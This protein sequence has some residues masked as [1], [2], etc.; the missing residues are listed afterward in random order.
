MK[1]VFTPRRFLQLLSN[2]D[3]FAWSAAPH[4]NAGLGESYSCK[5]RCPGDSFTFVSLGKK[6]TQIVDIRR[7]FYPR[8]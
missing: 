6:L 4:S 5:Y 1:D 3:R 2:S 7:A 8:V